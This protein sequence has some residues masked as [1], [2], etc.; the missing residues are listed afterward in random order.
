MERA[1]LFNNKKYPPL[2]PRRLR[3]TRAKNIT[4]TAS[5][6]SKEKKA[7][8]PAARGNYQPKPDSRS[9]S[10]SGRA[11]KL[12]GRAGAAQLRAHSSSDG[13][14]GRKNGFGVARTPEE[15]V[16]EGH[17]ASGNQGKGVLGK[18]KSNKKNQVLKKRTKR[19]VAFKTG[20]VSKGR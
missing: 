17:R 7:K 8:A 16:F 1:L 13:S 12:L 19:S 15:I 5:H 18:M 14:A 9:Q 4:K 3:V 10:L 2:L 11:G 6:R 20:K